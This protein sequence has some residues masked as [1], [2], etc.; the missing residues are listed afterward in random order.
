MLLYPTKL[1][2]AS[3][4]CKAQWVFFGDDIW[5]QSYNPMGKKH[6]AINVLIAKADLNL[7]ECVI[8]YQGKIKQL[9]AHFDDV[10]QR[11]GLGMTYKEM[12]AIRPLSQ[13]G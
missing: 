10:L 8:R 2:P 5:Y 11:M 7:A 13:M 4:P 6:R 12:G 1:T 3:S 9:T